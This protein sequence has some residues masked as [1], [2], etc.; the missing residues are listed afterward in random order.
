MVISV[1]IIRQRPNPNFLEKAIG[2][3]RLLSG[4]SWPRRRRQHQGQQRMASQGEMG[5][6]G[7]RRIP[8]WGLAGNRQGTVRGRRG[9]SR[10]KGDQASVRQGAGGGERRPGRAL[11]EG[12]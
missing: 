3:L 1:E 12:D 5:P 9:G 11:G 6:R 7:V 4:S 8:L 10:Q 2:V